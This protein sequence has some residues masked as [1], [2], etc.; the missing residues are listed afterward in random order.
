MAP[1]TLQGASCSW[2]GCEPQ[3]PSS[4]RTWHPRCTRFA[5]T[6]AQVSQSLRGELMCDI[7]L[8]Y[9]SARA[10]SRAT[11]RCTQWCTENVQPFHSE[12]Q[13]RPPSMLMQTRGPPTVQ[14]SIRRGL[15]SP[16]SNRGVL[17]PGRLSA[18]VDARKSPPSSEA[19]ESDERGR[20][21]RSSWQGGRRVQDDPHA[22]AR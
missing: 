2:P 3:A 16:S 12:N 5:S 13:R 4:I 21:T 15:F 10:R 18:I 9:P 1:S 19:E 6:S 7:S 11:A 22:R 17:S 8:S 14:A 20:E